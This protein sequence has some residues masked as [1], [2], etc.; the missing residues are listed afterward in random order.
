MKWSNSRDLHFFILFWVIHEN[1]DL[2]QK[3]DLGFS[4]KNA[5]K[6]QLGLRAKYMKRE[7]TC[8]SW[9][10]FRTH[11]WGK[12]NTSSQRN[13]RIPEQQ[14]G[15]RKDKWW[16]EATTYLNCG[17]PA[18]GAQRQHGG[19]RSHLKAI[20]QGVPLV[21]RGG[22][23]LGSSRRELFGWKWSRRTGGTGVGWTGVSLCY[24][25]G[26]REVSPFHCMQILLT[27]QKG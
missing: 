27:L 3:D 21:S 15:L 19:W 5:Q 22:D 6:E 23:G 7:K 16:R 2:V 25:S 17:P 18:W 26:K 12:G 11:F 24:F 10:V 8:N 4:M 9:S 1:L 13:I 20:R 14:Q